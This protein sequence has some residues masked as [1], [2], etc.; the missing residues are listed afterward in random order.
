MQD[1]NPGRGLPVLS[2]EEAAL[3]RSGIA[4]LSRLRRMGAKATKHPPL[5]KEVGRH[6]WRYQ[7][8]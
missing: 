7:T 4:E 3:M 1:A 5:E 6:M 2:P 8:S